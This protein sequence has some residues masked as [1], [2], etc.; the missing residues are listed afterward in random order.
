MKYIF[1]IKM[2]FLL[3]VFG[4]F[5]YLKIKMAMEVV[6]KEMYLR[7]GRYEW[8][9]HSFSDA[10]GHFPNV[11]TEFAFSNDLDKNDGLYLY[12]KYLKKWISIYK[13][14]LLLIIVVTFVGVS[15][16]FI[17]KGF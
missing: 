5:V 9:K 6:R 8:T 4:V 11:I 10:V 2:V 13:I 16:G 14:V 15:M 3:F 1:S 12:A 7:T 17:P